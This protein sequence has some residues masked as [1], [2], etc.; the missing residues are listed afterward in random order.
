MNNLKTIYL[1]IPFSSGPKKF[2]Q[3]KI[4]EECV[5][6]KEKKMFK[7]LMELLEQWLS[8]NHK[9]TEKGYRE[10]LENRFAQ[11]GSKD[12]IYLDHM[13]DVGSSFNIDTVENTIFYSEDNDTS[14]ID[15]F[16]DNSYMTMKKQNPTSD[17]YKQITSDLISQQ[18]QS[19]KMPT[20]CQKTNVKIIQKDETIVFEGH[21]VLQCN[22]NTNKQRDGYHT[23]R[24]N[25]IKKKTF[26]T[27]NK[28]LIHKN[29]KSSEN[30]SA[31]KYLNF[32][33][34]LSFNENL[35]ER[36]PEPDN[37]DSELLKGSPNINNL[38]LNSNS[39]KSPY[40]WK[41]NITYEAYYIKEN[42]SDA[43]K[44]SA[45]QVIK[46]G[47]LVD[48]TKNVGQQSL[49]SSTQN[50]NQSSTTTL[51]E[52]NIIYTYYPNGR[53]EYIGP[54]D[55]SQKRSGIGQWFY[56]NG[57]I[58]YKGMFK[59]GGPSGKECKI[60]YSN[61]KLQFCGEMNEG[62]R[63]NVGKCYYDNGVLCID[64]E[65]VDDKLEGDKI[66]IYWSNG[67]LQYFGK[68]KDG[69]CEGQGKAYYL[70]GRLR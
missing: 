7:E 62:K 14:A 25:F 33:S 65:F 11:G 45:V 23:E 2:P 40:L 55:S 58:R 59:N 34:D 9:F 67:K 5:I 24:P 49:S 69:K 21:L 53:I 1:E 36:K 70:A 12:S 31:E 61:E 29:E 48:D 27:V 50:L 56:S 41:S 47:I 18:T 15:F 63:H 64:G 20:P 35:T 51:N 16:K 4:E 30:K 19:S 38:Y 57:K 39:E 66:T 44:K 10:Y 46:E 22:K 8:E 54:K 42:L 32:G 52:D 6:I 43:N 17:F 37:N 3:L 13:S 68:M 60:Y 28:S 26:E